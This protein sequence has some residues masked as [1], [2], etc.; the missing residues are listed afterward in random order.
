MK[1]HSTKPKVSKISQG[2]A[3][4]YQ[5][6]QQRKTKL[7]HSGGNLISGFDITATRGGSTGTVN[8]CNTGSTPGSGN[9]YTTT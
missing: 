9:H 6:Q 3:N 2:G 5:T 8:N 4:I 7:I 1:K